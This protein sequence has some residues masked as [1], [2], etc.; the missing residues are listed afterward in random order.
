MLH[1]GAPYADIIKALDGHGYSLNADNL[2]RW[3][4]GGYQHW[5]REQSLLDDQQA[6]L[7]FATQVVN[8]EQGYLI[9]EASLRIAILRM[10]NLLLDFDPA[11]L[12]TRIAENPGAYARILNALCK[13]SSG[14]VGLER[15]RLEQ[16]GD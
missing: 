11:V 13:L 9:Q 12:K 4:A 10:Y 6:R 5:L 14:A 3:H 8:K 1:D 7:D 16:D 15:F 2:S